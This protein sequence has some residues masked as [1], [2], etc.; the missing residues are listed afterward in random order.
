MFYI[1]FY[2]VTHGEAK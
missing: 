2:L 1:L